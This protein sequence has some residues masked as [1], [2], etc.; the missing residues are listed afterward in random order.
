[1]RIRNF[2][3]FCVLLSNSLFA[4]DLQTDRLNA[5]DKY[6]GLNQPGKIDSLLNEIEKS[7]LNTLLPSELWNYHYVKATFL[8]NFENKYDSA[9]TQLCI[10][11]DIYEKNDNLFSSQYIVLIKTLGQYEKNVGNLK[12]ATVYMEE[13]LIKGW[14]FLFQ[15]QHSNV[16][17]Q[18]LGS[19]ATC[20]MDQGLD[21]E[22]EYLLNW[23]HE[24]TSHIYDAGTPLSY[25]YKYMLSYFYSKNKE[26]EKAITAVDDIIAMINDSNSVVM[27]KD[28]AAILF[29][30]AS[31]L[32]HLKQYDSAISLFKESINIITDNYGVSDRA[33]KEK[34]SSLFVTYCRNKDS[35]ECD[36][37]YPIFRDYYLEKGYAEDFIHTLQGAGFIYLDAKDTLMAQKMFH[38]AIFYQKQLIQEQL[39]SIDKYACLF[40]LHDLYIDVSMDS[41]LI[42]M[43]EIL[44]ASKENFLLYYQD[45]AFNKLI[46]DYTLLHEYDSVIEYAQ[47]YKIFCSSAGKDSELY[48]NACNRLAVAYLNVNKLKEAQQNL[49]IA[50]KISTP[51]VGIGDLRY[52]IL[53]HNQGKIY[54]LQKKYKKAV[55][56]LSKSAKLQNHLNG[57][58]SAKTQQYL[59]ESQF[60]LNNK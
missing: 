40:T 25:H 5:I 33:L 10:A 37:F 12:R 48:G 47:K 18:V 41:A 16:C 22:V 38:A 32:G 56:A 59:T 7:G 29:M 9:I 20:Y 34:Y 1:M 51:K 54:L 35:I 19:L 43:K 21:L 50:L 13:A 53:L 42:V 45:E 8:A 49:N 24:K 23:A 55:E 39:D 31:Y 3:F 11:K 14:S 6:F 17:G 52:A 27:P 2:I 4:Q 44:A 60:H 26:Y 46:T 28:Y 30:K 58:V 15:E 36:S 57:T